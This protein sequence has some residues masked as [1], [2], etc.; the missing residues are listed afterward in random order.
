MLAPKCSIRNHQLIF[1]AFR[2]LFRDSNRWVLTNQSS[3]TK[4]NGCCRRPAYL[5]SLT[6]NSFI[7]Q[8]WVSRQNRDGEICFTFFDQ[9]VTPLSKDTMI[10]DVLSFGPGRNGPFWDHRTKLK[11]ESKEL[12]EVVAKIWRVDRWNSDIDE[13]IGGWQKSDLIIIAHVGMGKPHLFFQ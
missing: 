12:P 1:K 8:Y 4:S 5:A 11:R 7:C 3:Q 2:E 13:K 9:L 6:I 10:T